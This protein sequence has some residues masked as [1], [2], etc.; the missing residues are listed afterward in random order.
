MRLVPNARTNTVVWAVILLS[1]IVI[2]ALLGM[3]M[4]VD[5]TGGT[6]LE[7]AFSGD[8][9]V[10]EI[11]QALQQVPGVDYSSSVIQP[12]AGDEVEGRTVVIIRTVELTNDQIA[13]TDETL[14]A[15]FGDVDNR[16]TEVVGPVV[17]SELI[18]QSVWAVLLSA[19]AVLVYLT[20]R[21]EYRFGIAALMA[22]AHDVFV[23][24]AALA[25][26][27][28]E[29]N[30]PFVAA[31]LTVVGYSLNNTIV[32]FDRV[33]EN[34]KYRKKESLLELVN[35]S[36][37]Q[38]LGRTINTTITTLLAL[39]ALLIFGGSTLQDFTMTLLVGVGLGTIS[40]LFFAPA[41]WLLLQRERKTDEAA[42]A[43]Q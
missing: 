2:W 8:V 21:F 15:A 31:I 24:L 38:T 3:N 41:I 34:L 27:R 5:F 26:Q 19:I 4:G 17:G 6:L 12:L 16:R 39:L 30:M 43:A 23:V 13:A 10:E 7:R 40:S 42:P 25:I 14:A 35:N 11:R 18:R 28:T 20:F 9:G 37:R 22:I 33:R 32:V 36:V 29:I 1:S